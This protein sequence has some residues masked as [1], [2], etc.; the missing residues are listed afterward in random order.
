M[1]IEEKEG[2]QALED[3]ENNNITL[4][5]CLDLNEEPEDLD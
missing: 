3:V 2:D 4:Y 5:E 1:D